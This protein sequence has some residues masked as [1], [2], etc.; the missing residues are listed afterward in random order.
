LQG[1]R[2]QW[3]I[4]IAEA[5]SKLFGTPQQQVYVLL[6]GGILGTRIGQIPSDYNLKSQAWYTQARALG[7]FGLFGAMPFAFVVSA[8]AAAAAA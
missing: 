5:S 4:S 1:F 2:S 8:A 7:I 3:I 6:P